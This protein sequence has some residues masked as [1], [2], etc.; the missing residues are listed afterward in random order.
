MDSDTRF[1]FRTDLIELETFL[2]QRLKEL[3]RST[4]LPLSTTAP[5][6]R[7]S[8]R[9]ERCLEFLNGVRSVLEI[10]KAPRLQRLLLIRSSNAHLERL[11]R[12]LNAH[13]IR[14]KNFENKKQI[15]L[16]WDL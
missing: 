9:S 5:G 16:K 11:V 3:K 2:S 7:N 14:A 10:L 15:S 13:L 4:T 12:D 6:L 1:Q 8:D